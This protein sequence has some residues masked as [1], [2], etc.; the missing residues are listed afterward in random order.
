VLDF[1]SHSGTTLIA[2]EKTGRRC[3]TTDLDPVFCEISIRRLEHLRQTAKT[4]WQNS[5]PFEKEISENRS[6]QAC[7]DDYYL[8][9]YNNTMDEEANSRPG[10]R[11]VI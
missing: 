7:L 5:N 1:F 2:A 6:L 8:K 3:F 11:A 10:K 9:N 4:G